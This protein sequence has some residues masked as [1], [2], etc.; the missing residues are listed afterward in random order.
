MAYKTSQ[1]VSVSNL[2][3]F[4]AMKTELQAKEVGEVLLGYMGKWAGRT[5]MAAARYCV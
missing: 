4:G 2:K 3:L 1:H 5:N